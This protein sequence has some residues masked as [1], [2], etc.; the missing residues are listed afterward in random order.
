MTYTTEAKVEALLQMDID[1]SSDPNT[2]EVA[3]WIAE[4]EADMDAQMLGSYTATDEVMDVPPVTGILPKDTAYW[5]QYLNQYGYLPEEGQIVIPSR[6][7]IVSISSLS[8]RTTGLSET[9]AWEALTE[10]PGS[11]A[12]YIQIKKRTKADNVLGFALYFYQNPPVAGLGRLK[13]T[14]NY[15]WNI[16]TSILGE[17][18]S[19]K[20]ALKV[21]DVLVSANIPAGT[22][23]YSVVDIRVAA[24]D[25]KRQRGLLLDRLA[26]LEE[27]YFPTRGLSS[28]GMSF[29]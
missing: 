11:T 10:G 6:I 1:G 22:Q 3:V 24:A 4:V 8:R 20:V 9:A 21:L 23:D 2:T 15:G 14:Y 29:I 5:M 12:S 27:K 13:M 16:D 7:P 25:I 17:Y 18:A 26:E 28:T 19:I